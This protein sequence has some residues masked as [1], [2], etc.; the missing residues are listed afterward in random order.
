MAYVIKICESCGSKFE[1]RPGKNGHVYHA[2]RHCNRRCW[3]SRYNKEDREHSVTGAIRGAT[4]NKIRY[5][6]TQKKSGAKTYVKEDQKHQHR[7]VAERILGRTLRDGEVVHHEDRDRKNNDPRNLVI[8]A[9][10][11]DHIR[12]HHNC[13]NKN[14]P[15]TCDCIW[16]RDLVG[17]DV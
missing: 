8:F 2:K 12:H 9:R 17:G 10:A 4:T 3:L 16:L 13:I 7:V 1:N 11:G 6:G 14:Q 5:R 15:C